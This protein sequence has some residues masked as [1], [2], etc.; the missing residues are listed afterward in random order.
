MRPSSHCL[1]SGSLLASGFH[2]ASFLPGAIQVVYGDFEVFRRFVLSHHF[3]TILYTGGEESL[4]QIRRDTSAQQNTRLVLCGGGKNAAYVASSANR[5]QAIAH[6]IYGATLDAGQRLESTSLVFVDHSIFSQFQ[7]QF[8]AAIKTMPIGVREDLSCPDKHVMG[9]LCSANGWERYLRFQG[10]AARE[11]DETLRWGKPIDNPAHGYFVSPGVH[12]MTPE[13]ILKSIYA[14]SA[15]FGPDVCLVPVLH[16][17]H[18]ISLL[19]ELCTTRCLGIHT[20]FL[21]EVLEI[22]KYSRIPTLLW[23]TATTNLSPLLPSMGRGKAGNSHV[24]GARFL[25]STVYPQILNLSF[26]PSQI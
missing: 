2:Q 26:Q 16:H 12:F 22:R 5:D 11:A 23:N 13:K 24:T 18:M 10:I 1:L 6:I 25:L 9:P 15:F 7:D 20:E 21:E 14:S 4:E 19:D 3:D 8:I 17:D